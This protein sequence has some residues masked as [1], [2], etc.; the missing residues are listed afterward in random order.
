MSTYELT[1]TVVRKWIFY[2][3]DHTLKLPLKFYIRTRKVVNEFKLNNWNLCEQ[4]KNLYISEML[5]EREIQVFEVKFLAPQ[6]F[7]ELKKIKQKPQHYRN[8]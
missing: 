7:F 5:K 2:H 4:L 3:L 8:Y 6:K 1:E